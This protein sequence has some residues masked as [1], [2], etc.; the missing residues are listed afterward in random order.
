MGKNR[1]CV[2]AEGRPTPVMYGIRCAGGGCVRRI[3]NDYGE[4][5]ALAARCNRA[6]LS[7]VHL[8]DV[9]EDFQRS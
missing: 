7:P 8:R 5:A 2:C 3:S 9:V 6:G 1:F 4:V